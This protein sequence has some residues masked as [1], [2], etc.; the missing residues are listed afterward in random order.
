VLAWAGFH[1]FGPASDP[2]CAAH[3]STARFRSHLR[4]GPGRQELLLPPVS[5]FLLGAVSL[6]DEISAELDPVMKFVGT[7]RVWLLRARVSCP[8]CA[9]APGV[10]SISHASSNR[11]PRVR[12]PLLARISDRAN[13]LPRVSASLA[14]STCLEY[15]T[16]ALPSSSPNP[17][18]YSYV[19]ITAHL[20][21]MRRRTGQVFPFTD[22]GELSGCGASRVRGESVRG[23]GRA[24]QGGRV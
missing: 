21:E 22:L 16:R 2:F 15:K 13:N 3:S 11:T 10:R 7:P 4:V 6:P 14:D 23:L 18:Y 12:L 9:W 1:L 8:R 20:R 24:N 19:A 17:R 5:T